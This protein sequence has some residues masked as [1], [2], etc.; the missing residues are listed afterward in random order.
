M[1]MPGVANQ[2]CAYLG[3]ER[4]PLH[5]GQCTK[6]FTLGNAGVS[7]LPPFPSSESSIGVGTFQ[8]LEVE[9]RSSGPYLTAREDEGRESSQRHCLIAEEK[10]RIL[11]GRGS[12]WRPGR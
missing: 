12:I 2:R 7:L 6:G 3:G 5:T 11:R 8:P 9:R 1:D 4:M 10:L